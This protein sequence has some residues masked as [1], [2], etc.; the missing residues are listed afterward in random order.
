MYIQLLDHF[1]NSQFYEHKIWHQELR[2][3]IDLLSMS[4]ASTKRYVF[5]CYWLM[6]F[7]TFQI[8]NRL[9]GDNMNFECV[10]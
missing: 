4:N 2:K 7:Q 1:D 5:R 3:K 8:V 10:D 9:V 6:K